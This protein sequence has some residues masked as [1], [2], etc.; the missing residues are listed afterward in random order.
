MVSEW[1][2]GDWLVV[3]CGS[4]VQ[5]LAISVVIFQWFILMVS[6]VNGG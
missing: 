6:V 4:N 1:L 2:D 5:L 3:G